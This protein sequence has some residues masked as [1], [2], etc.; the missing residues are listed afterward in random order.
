MAVWL[1]WAVAWLLGVFWQTGEGT[2]NWVWVYAGSAGV[3]AALV[4]LGPALAR[5]P[6]RRQDGQIVR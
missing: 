1:A 5:E 3:S 6:Q 2:L 4:V